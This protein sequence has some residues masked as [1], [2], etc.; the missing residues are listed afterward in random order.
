MSKGLPP[1]RSQTLS[2]FVCLYLKF[3]QSYEFKKH[4]RSFTAFIKNTQ[5]NWFCCINIKMQIQRYLVPLSPLFLIFLKVELIYPLF[6]LNWQSLR[7]FKCSRYV[8]IFL[9]Y[10]R[11]SKIFS[12]THSRHK[13]I[14]TYRQDPD[15]FE[16]PLVSER[17]GNPGWTNSKG[18]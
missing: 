10:L 2:E 5:Q 8:D 7:N 4:F 17:P 6:C 12:D 9:T 13:L 3:L 14:F 18:W 16:V 1:K 11:R 15:S